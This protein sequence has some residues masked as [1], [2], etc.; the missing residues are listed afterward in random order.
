VNCNG[1]A[2]DT[3]TGLVWAQKTGTFGGSSNPADPNNAN[4]LY[5]WST[6]SPYLLDGTAVTQ[7]LA[8]L[9][10]PPGFAGF[11]DWRLPVFEEMNS[12]LDCAAYPSS[13]IPTPLGSTGGFAGY[14]TATT[15]PY[16]QA[17]AYDIYYGGVSSDPKTTAL[18]VFAVRG[19]FVTPTPAP[20]PTRQ[21]TPTP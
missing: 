18:R 7:F 9:N 10:Q 8:A 4:N 12:I 1:T 13:C 16:T 17:N 5:T 11:T 19:A 20:T 2:T 15:D 6:G 21:P 14:W 3:E